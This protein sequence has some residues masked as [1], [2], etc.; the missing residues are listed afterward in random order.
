MTLAAGFLALPPERRS[1][2]FV[3]AATQRQMGAPILEKDFWV[4]WMLGL[5]FSDPELGPHLLFKG[6]TSLSKI[7]RVVQRF[8][9][10]VDLGITPAFLGIREG[11]F[12]GLPSRKRREA[13]LARMQK[14]CG[15]TLEKSI[16]PRLEKS[17]ES[18]LGAYPDGNGWLRYEFDNRVHSPILHF[19]YP[20]V[21]PAGLDYIKREV[22]LEIATLTD[23]RPTGRHA[24]KPWLADEFP[25]VFAEWKCDVTALEL[26]RT[27]WEKATILHAEFHKSPEKEIPVRYA[28]HYS[29]FARLLSHP[30]ANAFIADRVMCQ[31]VV[32]WKALVFPSKG[33]RYDLAGQGTFALVPPAHRLNTLEKDYLEMRPM[34][35]TEPQTFADMMAVL[36]EGE[37]R[38][39]AI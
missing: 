7:Y 15:E 2:A 16:I 14:L 10:D 12:E 18:L 36:A 25:D 33:A 8:S 24:V 9:E 22:K 29:D 35:L 21:L 6:G 28:R 23:Q 20:T 11:D 4:C 31:R 19:R 3:Q 32:D 27:F 17:I 26:E 39:N 1:I 37:K 30:Q 13:E 5:I 38:I 34:F